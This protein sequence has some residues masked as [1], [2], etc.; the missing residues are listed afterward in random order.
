MEML[1]GVAEAARRIGVSRALLYSWH[2]AR[3][4]PYNLI[5]VKLST[6]L[7]VDVQRL[8]EL[9]E[10]LRTEPKDTKVIVFEEGQKKHA[11]Q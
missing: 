3:K 9:I 10:S 5:F 4:S 6:R 2:A 8:G 7:M 1:I 11:L